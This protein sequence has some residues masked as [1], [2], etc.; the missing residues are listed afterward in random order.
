MKKIIKL[1]F[2]FVL[3]QN[4]IAQENEVKKYTSNNK[5]KIYFYWGGNRGYF[6]KSDINFYGK[7]YNFTI[8]DAV[9]K[10]KPLGWHVDYINPANMTIPQTN[11]RIGYFI[12]DYYSITL[13]L[14]HM[15][16]VMQLNQTTSID[17]YINVLNSKY[18]GIYNHTEMILK[19]DF[20]AFEHTDGLNYINADITRHDDI[21]SWIGVWNTDKFQIQLYEGAG[22][23]MVIPRTNAT[24]LNNANYDE[25][26]LAGFGLSAKAGL[27]FTFFKYFQ[28]QTD[29]KAG[30]INM[31]DVRTTSNI[32]DGAKHDFWFF[33]TMIAFG[34]NFYL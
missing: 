25:F 5:G 30:Y 3:F 9:A 14:E 13:G 21:S 18:N 22:A 1:M 20:I 11:F 16:Y 15:K 17:G 34:G 12:N 33:Q 26:H 4:V 27:T 2:I 7:D 29:L 10:D 8:N 28:I 24:I 23:G 31:Y 6:S 32:A 19:D